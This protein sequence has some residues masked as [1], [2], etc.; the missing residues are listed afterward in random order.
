M[1]FVSVADEK[2]A[3]VFD[4]PKGFVRTLKGLSVKRPSGDSNTEEVD[5]VSDTLYFVGGVGLESIDC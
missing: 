1:R 3:R 2:V 4:A 5:E